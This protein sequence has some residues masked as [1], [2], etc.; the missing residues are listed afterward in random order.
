VP[1]RHDRTI[2]TQNPVL[3][4]LREA[5]LLNLNMNWIWLM[6]IIWC[7]WHMGKDFATQLGTLWCFQCQNHMQL[8]RASAGWNLSW[9]TITLTP[10]NWRGALGLNHCF[11]W[12]LVKTVIIWTLSSF[13]LSVNA[14]VTETAPCPALPLFVRQTAPALALPCP[15]RPGRPLPLPLFVR[16]TAP[17]LALGALPCPCPCPMSLNRQTPHFLRPET[18]RYGFF[19]GYGFQDLDGQTDRQTDRHCN[20][21]IYIYLLYYICPYEMQPLQKRIKKKRIQFF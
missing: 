18:K 17:A 10:W 21:N 8:K 12:Q 6:V 3:I 1:A 15:G 5:S 14:S 20:F 2:G 16:Q 7:N 4:L 13:G 11:Q 19:L 9:V